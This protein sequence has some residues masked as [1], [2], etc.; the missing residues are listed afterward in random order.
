[1]KSF[2]EDYGPLVLLFVLPVSMVMCLLQYL[3]KP[4][5]LLLLIIALLLSG[6]IILKVSIEALAYEEMRNL[7]SIGGV[8]LGAALVIW[9]GFL[10]FKPISQ[11]TTKTR[12]YFETR[13]KAVDDEE[14]SVSLDISPTSYTPGE[15]GQ[16]SIQVQNN[17][18]YELILDSV[19]F[20]T[21]NK[22]Y[23][24]FVVDYESA[25]PPISERKNKL[26]VSIALF[27]G[28]DQTHILPGETAY[29]EVEIVANQPGDYTDNYYAVLMAGVN[30]KARP[31][32]IPEATEDFY[33]VI[34][35][36]E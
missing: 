19:M 36:E 17:S 24:G 10:I 23:D 13:S 4:K 22:F 25:N 9:A 12:M 26:G 35:A 27:F 11:I 8:L 33:L 7:T 15:R 21:G 28:E 34:L 18:Q 14:I 29:F 32:K 31:K 16:I 2:F 20:E 30:S 3:I 5:S 1:M 6:L